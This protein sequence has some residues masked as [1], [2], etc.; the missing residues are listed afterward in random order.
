MA[1]GTFNHGS[2]L[3]QT[4]ALDFAADTIKVALLAD[5]VPYV[6]DKDHDH[7]DDINPSELDVSGYPPGFA[8]AGRATLAGKTITEDSVNDRSVFDAT[9]PAPWT[10]GAGKNV[11]GAVVYYHITD[12]ATSVPIWYLDFADF[13]TNGGAFSLIFHANGIGY[14]QQ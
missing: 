5:D 8:G 12:D 9:D 1:S 7:M 3:I 6:F 14:V 13:A 4:G 10:L 11:V 2:H